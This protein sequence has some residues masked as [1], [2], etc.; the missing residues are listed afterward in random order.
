[1]AKSD[2][3]SAQKRGVVISK[4]L[5]AINAAS[6]LGARAINIGVLIWLQQHL[7][8]RI[9]PEE[10]A[11]YPLLM[12]IMICVPLLTTILTSGLGRFIVEAY[13]RGD[14]GQVT[15]IVSTMLPPL[16][17]AGLVVLIGGWA[18]A[19][20]IDHVLAIAPAQASDARF[21]LALLMFSAALS[22]PAAAL[23]VGLYVRQKFVLQNAITLSAEVFRLALLLVLLFGLGT[24]V[25]W[26]VVA[27]VVA[28]LMTLLA[29][30]LISRR[31]IP[32]LRFRRDAIHWPLLPKLTSFGSWNF[33]GQVAH[34]LRSAAD[35]L[36]LN[37]WGTAL[38][39]TCFHLGNLP[40]KHIRQSVSVAMMPLQ[41]PMT[42]MHATRESGRL[43]RTYLLSS[44][45]GMWMALAIAVP[46]LIFSRE[47]VVLYVGREFLAAATVLALTMGL[48]PIT[49]TSLTLP[50]I[51]MATAQLSR[52]TLY[53]LVTHVANIALTVYLVRG[54]SMGATG[55]AVAYFV[56]G[57]ACQP[58]FVPLGL[59]LA[60]VTFRQW[61]YETVWLGIAP[62]LAA[63]GLWLALHFIVQP[64]TWLSLSACAAAGLA[65]YVAALFGFCL[66]RTERADLR[67]V[68]RHLRAV[69]SGRTRAAA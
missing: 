25:R 51:A 55:V 24:R 11:L 50:N 19:W 44:R 4:K 35:P 61:L 20:N 60:D 23:S 67:R 18:L 48:F 38:D 3:E 29:M 45:Y 49:Y 37:S 66:N 47:L 31:L 33:I 14:E 13:A 6:A 69:L 17:A 54:L 56:T 5:V 64:S 26:V 1:M 46:L 2:F 43:G 53:G 42:A 32:V 27:S 9:S 36:I 21:M 28:N 10:Y 59:R 8:R 16:A 39:V 15:R 58:L 30:V 57:V 34:T 7:L 68:W 65:V 40:N 62:G 41:P 22:V 52:M 12:A 63:T